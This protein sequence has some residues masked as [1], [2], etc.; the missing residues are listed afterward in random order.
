[1]P[2]VLKLPRLV[3]ALPIPMS[4]S[5]SATEL[6]SPAQKSSIARM[7]SFYFH[8]QCPILALTFIILQNQSQVE[9]DQVHAYQLA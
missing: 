5:L 9:R 8:I 4:A 2:E 1:M 3:A 7:L 6:K